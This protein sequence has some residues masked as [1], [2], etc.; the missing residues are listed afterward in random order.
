M[1]W[2]HDAL[3]QIPRNGRPFVLSEG[4]LEAPSVHTLLTFTVGIPLWALTEMTKKRAKRKDSPSEELFSQFG[5]CL[6]QFWRWCCLSP[7]RG[8]GLSAGVCR[9]WA[10]QL[11]IRLYRQRRL[12]D[13]RPVWTAASLARSVS[14]PRVPVH[15]GC[16]VHSISDVC[17]VPRLR[18]SPNFSQLNN[19]QGDV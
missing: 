17:A 18:L 19:P 5:K 4:D 14:S 15:R 8:R 11:F 2:G 7:A 12:P 1:R 13:Q 10:D 9:E 6:I 16:W 3:V